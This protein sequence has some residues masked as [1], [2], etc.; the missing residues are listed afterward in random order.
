MTDRQRTRLEHRLLLAFQL[1]DMRVLTEDGRVLVRWKG[2]RGLRRLW[3][4]ARMWR[5]KWLP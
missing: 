5:W 4:L 3:T 1:G 2:Q